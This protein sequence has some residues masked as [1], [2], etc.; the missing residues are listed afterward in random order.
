MIIIHLLKKFIKKN[1]YI[2]LILNIW[3]IFQLMKKI[4]LKLTAMPIQSLFLENGI[5]Y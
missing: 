2:F 3:D 1:L 5:K 4:K